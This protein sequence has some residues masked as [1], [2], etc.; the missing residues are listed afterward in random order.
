MVPVYPC[1]N[2][3]FF[4]FLCIYETFFAR[5]WHS[6]PDK[7]S[8]EKMTIQSGENF[9]WIWS[10]FE[11]LKWFC[12]CFIFGLSFYVQKVVKGCQ[13]ATYPVLL[14]F[15]SRVKDPMYIIITMKSLIP[16]FVHSFDV[17]RLVYQHE[18]SKNKMQHIW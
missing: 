11:I 13:P 12:F 10:G 7:T 17:L 9:T 5:L 15:Q 4:K 2:V 14:T 3:M 8:Q 16:F 18:K 1:L 6:L